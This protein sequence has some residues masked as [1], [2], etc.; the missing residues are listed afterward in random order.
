[1]EKAPLS[2]PVASLTGNMLRACKD[3]NHVVTSQDHAYL[4]G[5]QNQKTSFCKVDVGSILDPYTAYLQHSSDAAV[6]QFCF[7]G[8]TTGIDRV[9]Q[10]HKTKKPDGIYGLDGHQYSSASKPGLYIIKGEKRMVNK[11]RK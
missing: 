9:E 11:Q 1:M 5:S 3:G 6:L 2:M 10:D 7:V 8:D 4:I